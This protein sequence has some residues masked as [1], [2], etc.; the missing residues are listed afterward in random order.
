[1]RGRVMSFHVE[2]RSDIA[3][4]CTG[5]VKALRHLLDVERDSIDGEAPMERERRREE[6]DPM[7]RQEREEEARAAAAT[8]ICE[9]GRYLRLVREPHDDNDVLEVRDS[10]E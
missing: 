6:E 8:A 9:L 10:F 1:M 4:R 2:V 3:R 5:M 7:V